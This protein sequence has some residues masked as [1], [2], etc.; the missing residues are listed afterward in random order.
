MDGYLFPLPAPL[1]L[2]ISVRSD[3]QYSDST[4]TA[5]YTVQWADIENTLHSQ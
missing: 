4:P 1:L 3:A 2:S 5:H